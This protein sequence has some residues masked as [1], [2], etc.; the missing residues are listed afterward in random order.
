MIR[1]LLSLVLIFFAVTSYAQRSDFWN[2]SFTKADSIATC[3]KGHNLKHPDKLAQLLT[4]DLPTDVEKFRS[5]FYWV[6]KNISYDVE[7]LEYKRENEKR[8]AHNRIKLLRWQKKFNRKSWSRVIRKK[9]AICIGY[10]E[11]LES[12]AVST[13]ITCKTISGYARN[14]DGD[15]GD[16]SHAWN[17]V[18]LN[19]RWYLCDAT[20]AS[21]GV[22]ARRFLRYFEDAYFLPEPSLLI[23]SHFPQDSVWTLLYE[24]PSYHEFLSAPVAGI[25]FLTTR[26]SHY[27]P[28][29]AVLKVAE[30]NTITFSFTSNVSNIEQVMVTDRYK[31]Q[32]REVVYHPL[33]NRE[34]KYEVV[35]AFE[36]IGVHDVRISANGRFTL[37]YDV[38]VKK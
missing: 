13:G 2:I 3:Y 25:G 37:G 1:F 30:C 26:I 16:I 22:S 27:W 14:D 6:A 35:Y 12:M 8:Y 5:L 36:G 29:N 11:L 28:E 18:K 21:G 32:R 20:W 23:A 24:K 19:D 38:Y 7:L 34:G 31:R 10:S 17:A 15:N 33:R 4:R 9:T